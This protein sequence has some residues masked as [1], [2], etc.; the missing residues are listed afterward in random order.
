MT[1]QD[2]DN[3]ENNLIFGQSSRQARWYDDV[4][5][6]TL[7]IHLAENLPPSVQALVGKNLDDYIDAYRQMRRTAYQRGGG[8][9]LVS[10][11]LPKITGLYKA[12]ERRR[13]YDAPKHPLYRPL[14]FMAL[15]PTYFL[16]SYA[17]KM[18]EIAQYYHDLDFASQRTSFSDEEREAL[19][20]VDEWLSGVPITLK[21]DGGG[22][23]IGRNKPQ[24]NNNDDVPSV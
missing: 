1:T 16:T 21:E 5:E 7:A 3:L 19:H 8:G 13:W 22:I 4:G 17:D 11:G 20:Q 10:I 23:R 12:S 9:G 18:I 6:M 15:V 24:N 2:D 14:N